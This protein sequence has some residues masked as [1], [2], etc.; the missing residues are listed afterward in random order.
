MRYLGID[1]GSRRIGLAVGDGRLRIASPLET[2][3]AA[4]DPTRDAAAVLARAAE[5]EAEALVVGMPLNMDGS[6]GP[7]A[8]RTRRF[9]AALEA[10]GR[11]P[12]HEQDERLT[13]AAAD[14]AL[15]AA[16]VAPRRRRKRRDMLAARVILQ[17]FL[18][19]LPARDSM[20]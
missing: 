8:Q 16:G 4:D 13:S 9:I 2:V 11:L 15:D 3:A 5:A 10:A 18:D 1:Y 17:Q 14:E 19:A 6:S 7:Q 20:R 12:V